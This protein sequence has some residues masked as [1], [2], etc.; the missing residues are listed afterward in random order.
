M[1]TLEEIRRW[2]KGEDVEGFPPNTEPGKPQGASHGDGR[3]ID[4]SDVQEEPETPRHHDLAKT[5]K[6]GAGARSRGSASSSFYTVSATGT[7]AQLKAGRYAGRSV[8]ELA[9]SKDGRSYL[10]WILREDFPE[11]LKGV[12]R[13]QME[14]AES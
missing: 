1:A 3:V 11:E 13:H 6:R 14:E 4:E 12:I 7:D 10:R 5:R 8:S 2:M 9:K